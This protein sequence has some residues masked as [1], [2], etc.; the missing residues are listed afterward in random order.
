M[1]QVGRRAAAGFTLLELLLSVALMA[2]VITLAYGSL[3][4]AAGAVRSGEALI[5]RT[6]E[7]R[8][9]QTFLRRQLQQMLPSIFRTDPSNGAVT[10][11]EGA[12][13]RIRFVAPMPGYLSRGGAH[14]QE[15]ALVP[16][17]GG[18]RLEFRHA[19]LNGFDPEQGF[20]PEREPVVLIDGI[21]DGRFAFRAMD[22]DRLGDWTSE[23]ED[24]DRLPLLLRLDLEFGAADA[25]HWPGFE[26]APFASVA[27][28][29][30][31]F[32]APAWP[33]WG[34]MRPPPRPRDA[35]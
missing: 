17:R 8:T 21:R 22:G 3:R 16:D 35:Q 12:A 5:E 30:A 20:D 13:H 2:L 6:E 32:G 9:T 26:V 25:R 27:G 15:L 1:R 11:F 29:G 34:R 24:N 7:L 4:A 18:Y 33:G 19:Q 23:W 31:G 10:R 28:P 14:V